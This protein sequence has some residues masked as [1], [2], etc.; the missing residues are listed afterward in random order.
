MAISD[1]LF[2]RIMVLIKNGSFTCCSFHLGLDGTTLVPIYICI[3]ALLL[4]SLVVESLGILDHIFR[5]VL[6]VL[7]LLSQR[8]LHLEL[9]LL[10]GAHSE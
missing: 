10:L 7:Q 6:V 8:R 4:H 1:S 5:I 2:Q 3:R 9:F